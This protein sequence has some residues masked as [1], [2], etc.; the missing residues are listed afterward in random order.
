MLIEFEPGKQDKTLTQQHASRPGNI[1]WGAQ[2]FGCT[3]QARRQ[4]GTV[5]SLLKGRLVSYQ[6]V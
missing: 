3:T 2:A 5:G 1:K 6:P 4:M